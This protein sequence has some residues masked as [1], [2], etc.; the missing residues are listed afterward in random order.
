MASSP[1][2]L[3]SVDPGK[4]KC[5]FAFFD[6]GRLSAVELETPLL[7]RHF[8]DDKTII[9]KPDR[10]DSDVP[11]GDIIDLCIAAG[12]C[13]PHGTAEWVAPRAWKGTVKKPITHMRVWRN[14]TTAERA[15]VA[16]YAKRTPE[17]I[18][19]KILEACQ[20]LA[21]TGKVTEYSWKLHNVLDAV[22]IGLWRLGRLGR[23]GPVKTLKTK[24]RTKT[25]TKKKK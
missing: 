1:D 6:A 11:L 7:A 15:V 17:A 24:A 18:E 21:R 10:Q 13:D 3:V 20:R 4:L 19:K 12:R 14:L 16:A 8:P 9:E 22:G 5:A 25:W 23:Q 2:A